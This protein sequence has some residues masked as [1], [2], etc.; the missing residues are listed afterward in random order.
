M[1]QVAGR[2]G[3]KNKQGKV[4]IQAFNASHEI[5][6]FVIDNN[7]EG[8]VAHQLA[9]RKRFNY[10]PFHRLIQLT[11]KHAGYELLNDASAEFARLLRKK[12][13]KRVLGPEYPQ[14]SRIR[15]LYLK[16]ILI[17]LEQGVNLAKAKQ[18]I[19]A[20]VDELHVNRIYNQVR[21]IVDVDPV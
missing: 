1:A 11:L 2:S 13:G 20:A 3:R 5:I 15:N 18:E 8:M 6:R 9:E 14:V 21:V 4:L 19:L 10:P 12:F 17:K 16:N 7:Y